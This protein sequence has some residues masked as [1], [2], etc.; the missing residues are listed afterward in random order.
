MGNPVEEFL[1]TAG[2]W[3]NFKAGISGGG[4]KGISGAMGAQVPTALAAAAVTGAAAGVAK[5]FEAV[6]ERINKARDYKAMLQATPDLRRFDASHTQMMYNSLRTLAPTL[7]RDPLVAGSFVRDAM[8]L[9]PEH[10][11]AIPPQTAKLL[12]ETQAKLNRPGILGQ[13]TEA[14]GKAG[15]LQRIQP[16]KAGP[17]TQESWTEESTEAGK[18]TRTTTRRFHY[19]QK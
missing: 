2:F 5:G 3:D 17:P 7:A 10:G 13:M 1:K 6:R 8:H 15:P 4:A 12:A 16:E 18:P 14:M 11:P 19:A 9:S